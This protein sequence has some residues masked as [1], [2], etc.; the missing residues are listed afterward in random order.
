MENTYLWDF[1]TTS[2][3]AFIH[4][5][6]WYS[7]DIAMEIGYPISKQKSLKRLDI[8]SSKSNT[9]VCHI[10][11]QLNKI[12]VAIEMQWMEYY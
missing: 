5:I 8:I 6:S 2:N 4:L 3:I 1:A 10:V 12:Y 7:C 11:I 9:D